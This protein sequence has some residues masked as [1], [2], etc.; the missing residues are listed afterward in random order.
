M[1]PVHHFG[2]MES[3]HRRALSVEVS[4][5]YRKQSISSFVSP[6]WTDF[7]ISRPRLRMGSTVP[8][9]QVPRAYR[10]TNFLCHVYRTT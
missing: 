10:S 3:G 4:F 2:G 6:R 5:D 9:P 1:A 7:H 8:G